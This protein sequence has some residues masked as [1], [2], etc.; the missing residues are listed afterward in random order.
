MW[1]FGK[2]ATMPLAMTY[3]FE[4]YGCQMNQAE[5]ASIERILMERG[6]SEA[7]SAEEADLVLINTC[8][9]RKTAENRVAGRLAYFAAL[10]KKRDFFLVLAGCMAERL[11]DEAMETYPAIDAVVGMFERH[12][13][14]DV[15]RAA[16]EGRPYVRADDAPAEGTYFFAPTSYEEG[17][18]QSF[19]PIMNGCNNFCSYCIVP[20][21]RG[22]EVSRPVDD[23]LDEVA[24]LGKKGAREITLLGQNVNSY[25]QE[26]PRGAVGFPELLR[27]VADRAEEGGSIRWIRFLSSHPRDF[28]DEL[29]DAVAERESL[30]AMI[31]LPVQHG[32]TRI[33]KAMNRGYTREEYIALA[34]KIR[35]RVPDAA[36]STD[37]LVG[38][39]G[40]T[41][42]DFGEVLSLMERV[43]FESA[44]MY[45]FNPRE[46]TRAFSLPDQV[47][48][49]ARK[50]R[51]GRVVDLQMRI[52]A[53][54]MQ[55]RVG[56]CVDV[57]VESPSR[58]NPNEMFGHTERGEMVV[59]E[60]GLGKSARGSFVRAR[61]LCL[62]GKTFRA[63]MEE[64]R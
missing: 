43:R 62:R 47:P 1:E 59:F 29:I 33:L 50:K 49:A 12:T 53:E 36:L 18:F 24:F 15:F 31:H 26:G 30:C 27:L 20:Y 41:E 45:H 11:R 16:E 28:S 32:S 60:E 7:P 10:K 55:R 25:R 19:V 37:I 42:E 48:E 23:I 38:F 40:E 34:E 52:S 21:V 2:S 54:E 39:P 13:F 14:T 44:Y 57:L 56:R 46:G 22:R 8:S 63:R 35:S 17:A 6:W 9:V 51:L 3:F 4:T 5:S 58:N 61:L 64:Q